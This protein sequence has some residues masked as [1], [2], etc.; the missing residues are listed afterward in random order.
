MNNQAKVPALAPLTSEQWR[1]ILLSIPSPVVAVV[2][3]AHP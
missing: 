3:E 1:Q 2:A